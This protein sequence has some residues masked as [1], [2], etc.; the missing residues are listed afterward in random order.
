MKKRSN[1]VAPAPYQDFT[2]DAC[3]GDSAQSKQVTPED[4]TTDH[5]QQQPSSKSNEPPFPASRT[6]LVSERKKN[7][8]K[9][10]TKA[11]TIDEQV[12]TAKKED[13]I[14]MENDN[15]EKEQAKHETAT[16]V[17]KTGYE[18]EA[19]EESASKW[20]MEEEVTAPNRTCKAPT[21]QSSETLE[22]SS[23]NGSGSA[24]TGHSC[25]VVHNKDNV[26]SEQKRCEQRDG[27]KKKQLITLEMKSGLSEP[28]TV[29]KK[30]SK[31]KSY[32]RSAVKQ[33]IEKATSSL[34]E[35]ATH[36]PHARVGTENTSPLPK[37]QPH[38][39]KQ[40]FSNDS[41]I[42]KKVRFNLE[43]NIYYGT[44]SSTTV[45][46]TSSYMG[47]SW[48]PRKPS[49]FAQQ[50]RA[51]TST[52]C[53]PGGS[54][55]PLPIPDTKPK[56]HGGGPCLPS[57]RPEKKRDM[58]KDFLEKYRRKKERESAEEFEGFSEPEPEEVKRLLEQPITAKLPRYPAN[59]DPLP[60]ERPPGRGGQGYCL[61]VLWA[62]PEKSF[63]SDSSSEGR[64]MFFF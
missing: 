2:S 30:M 21:G 63:L 39:R 11:D 29:S 24:G 46:P 23:S 45:S 35:E 49:T 62:K 54:S 26:E 3:D 16:K 8:L 33:Q 28:P 37:G 18:K 27:K 15:E 51:L 42:K 43:H 19:V 13:H 31:S 48:T 60:T 1:T 14:K 32:K 20:Q 10:T 5:E 38:V 9:F 12:S 59:W 4:I 50:F 41:K 47:H 34:A 58:V 52:D 25:K 61:G 56:W 64:H 7:V 53:F 6:V 17:D 44:S 57:I 22:T 55:D 36:E 40:D